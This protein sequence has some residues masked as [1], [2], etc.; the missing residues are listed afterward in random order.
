MSKKQHIK[1]KNSKYHKNL[2]IKKL[3]IPS[4][5][6]CLETIDVIYVSIDVIL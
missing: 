2:E 4:L 1:Y 6:S 5:Q 3:C